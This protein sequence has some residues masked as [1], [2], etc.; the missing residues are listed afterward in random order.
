MARV[1]DGLLGAA[2]KRTRGL[3]RVRRPATERAPAFDLTYVRAGPRGGTPVVIVPGGPGLAAVLPYR[4]MRRMAA[5]RGLDVIMVEHRGV[6]L[7]RR[8]TAG[9]DLPPSGMW[10]DDVL[11]DIAAV[12]DR[13]NVSTA[14]IVGSSYGSY[15]ASGFGVRH[16]DRVAGMLLDSALQSTRDLALERARVRGLFWDGDDATTRVVRQL[17]ESGA[18]ERTLL[19]VMRAAYELCG[20]ALTLRMLRRRLR[21]RRDPVWTALD[22]YAGRG[23]A[24]PRIAHVYDF[25][26]AGVIAFRELDYGAAPDGLPLDPALTYAPLADRFPPFAG[27]PFDLP[28][29]TPGFPWP[30]VLLCGDRDLR[31]PPAIA[32]C[33][34]T[35]AQDAV[36]VTIE[37]GHS[38]LETHPVALLHAVERLVA[39]EQA[40]LP[41]ETTLMNRMPRRG[42]AARF[43]ALLS[44]VSRLER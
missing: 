3:A 25:D 17:V 27:E 1:V 16:P 33:V 18:D 30:M 10:V 41:G 31:T 6:G 2:A 43:P 9:Q 26:L 42:L 8:D 35:T 15:L 22:A 40:R 38:A 23:A 28:A 4:G 21:G 29:E 44:A 39:G 36:L 12:L 34:A 37:N 24:I 20:P 32:E 7:S 14:Y 11:D 19:D 5:R 13:E